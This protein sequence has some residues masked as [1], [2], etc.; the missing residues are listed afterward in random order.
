MPARRFPPTLFAAVALFTPPAA[1][2]GEDPAAKP[3]A[4]PLTSL[5]VH[6]ERVNLHGP[7]NRQRLVVLGTYA[8]G[9][10]W[11]LT[12]EAKF[13]SGAAGVAAV[14]AAGVVRPAGDGQT[15][16]TAEAGGRSVS[17]PVVVKDA[18][19]EWPVSF[20]REVV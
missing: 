3:P 20:S 19:A 11:D 18:T 16:V 15:A 8:D 17:V 1:V 4:A 5:E 12:R 2:R 7:R 14:D 13:Q 6:P 9:R 10:R